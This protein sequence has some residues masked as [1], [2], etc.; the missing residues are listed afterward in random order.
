VTLPL[1]MV[2]A[3]KSG[4]AALLG[5]LRNRELLLVGCA[6]LRLNENP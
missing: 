1:Q 5:G 6:L 3:E 2:C 4:E